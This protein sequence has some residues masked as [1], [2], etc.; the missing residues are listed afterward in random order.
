MIVRPLF[1]E[2]RGCWG[3][4]DNDNDILCD[5]VTVYYTDQTAAWRKTA[6]CTD[7]YPTDIRG[8]AARFC[9]LQYAQTREREGVPNE[10]EYENDDN[11]K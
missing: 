6:S 4:A 10:Y 5:F 2:T 8:G 7:V 11:N 9:G 1:F 3:L